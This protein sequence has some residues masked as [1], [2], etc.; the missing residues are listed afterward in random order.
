METGKDWLDQ[1]PNAGTRQMIRHLRGA[2]AL[3]LASAMVMVGHGLNQSH[4]GVRGS[5]EGIS[6]TSLGYVFAAFALGFLVSTRITPRLLVRVGHVRVYA[7]YV[8]GASVSALLY[9]AI[10]DPV[11]WGVFRFFG[12]LCMS[13][14][15][16]VSESWLNGLIGSRDRGKMLSLYVMTQLLGLICGQALLQ[17]GPIEGYGLFVTA[18]ALISLS[19]IPML[20]STSPTPAF[21]TGATMTFRELFRI[22]PLG[23]AGIF[24][25]GMA[26]AVAYQMGPVFG[27]AVGLT[28]SEV[29][30]FISA[31]YVGGTLS[32]Y[33]VGWLSDRLDRRYVAMGLSAC[34]ALVSVGA[35]AF[36]PGAVFLVAIAASIGVT[37]PPMYALLVAHANDFVDAERSP[38]VSASLMFLQGIGAAAG[39][40]VAGFA[41]GSVG[42]YGYFLVLAA[43]ALG[44]LAFAAY[45]S[46]IRPAA[47]PGE[48]S[49]FVAMPLKATEVAA[50]IYG[51]EARR[52]KEET[53]DT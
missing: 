20:L 14:I 49:A 50:E 5:L 36:A 51:E 8:A 7:A 48:G 10:V 26:F 16:V 39:P 42:P 47:T 43:T 29:A 25:I 44:I 27:T 40:V 30:L 19:C 53:P 24:F 11:A 32:Q 12:G 23:A 22:S 34:A 28:V 15:F 37:I 33:P 35:W 4:L 1:R 2:W 45:R 18:S 13:G 46:R 9:G 6:S 21:R 41:M 3:F 17:V 52:T 31:I 38:A